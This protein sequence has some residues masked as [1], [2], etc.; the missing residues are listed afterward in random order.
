MV[1]IC[2]LS[3]VHQRRDVRIVYKECST[4]A[5]AG[6]D[7]HLIIGDGKGDEVFRGIKI[8][9]CPRHSN[10]FKRMLLG[11]LQILFKAMELKAAVYHFHDVEL[12]PVGYILKV[13]GYSVIYDVHDDVPKQIMG[14]HYVARPFKKILAQAVRF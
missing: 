13:M 7:T 4:L 8:H 11:P 6:Y 14:K 9:G 2:H 1:K 12:L 3:T 5:K 10:R